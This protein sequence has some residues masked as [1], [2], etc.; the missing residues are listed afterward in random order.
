MITK[1][2]S[3]SLKFIP[4]VVLYLILTTNPVRLII[5]ALIFRKLRL[6]EVKPTNDYMANKIRDGNGI[7]LYQT[8]K[9]E[10]ETAPP[11]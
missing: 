2:V 10:L 5:S 4:G 9:R 7:L 8:P 1:V 6:K 3:E 11:H